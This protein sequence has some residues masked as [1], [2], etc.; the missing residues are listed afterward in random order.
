VTLLDLCA[1]GMRSLLYNYKLDA[2]SGPGLYC[3]GAASGEYR[4]GGVFKVSSV[5]SAGPSVCV[6]YNKYVVVGNCFH[7]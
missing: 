3:S 7:I 1:R 4:R 2:S 5:N 6:W